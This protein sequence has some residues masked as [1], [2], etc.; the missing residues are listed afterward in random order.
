M[1]NGRKRVLMLQVGM[2]EVCVWSALV[3]NKLV[4][5]FLSD[6]NTNE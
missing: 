6:A 5:A 3:G 1:N 4:S 2:F